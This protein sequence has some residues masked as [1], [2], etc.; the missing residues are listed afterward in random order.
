M[1]FLDLEG[2]GGEVRMMRSIERGIQGGLPTEISFE[3]C[4]LDPH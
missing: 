1:A 4:A 3:L 2:I